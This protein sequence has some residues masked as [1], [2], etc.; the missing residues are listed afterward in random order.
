MTSV[1]VVD[2]VTLEFVNVFPVGANGA[3]VIGP[4]P[5]IVLETSEDPMVL[6]SVKDADGTITLVADPVKVQA[7]TAQAWTALRLE[8][9][10]LLQQSDWVALSDAHLSQDKKDAW[11]AYRQALR[12]LPDELA[13]TV[14]EGAGPPDLFEWPLDPTVVVQAPASGSRLSSLL[15]HADVEPVPPV[16][17]VTEV[18]EPVQ[19]VTEVQEVPE[20]PVAEEPVVEV[21]VVEPVVESPVVVEPVV[22]VPEVQEVVEVP[23]V[24]EVPEV[25][26]VVEVPEVQEVVEV[27]VV[28]EVPEVPE[29][30]EVVEV[31]EV[32]EVV[33]VPEPA[34]VELAASEPVV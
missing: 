7:K 23:V 17:E 8:R 11:F 32:Q 6:V 33:E 28:E 31:P 5:Q 27:P 14:P 22:E 2:S 21:P 19:E 3:V 30:Q 4:N 1:I 12:D 15:T 29:V 18:V 16:V 13:N 20:V 10:R 9:N 26:E 34:P 24:E 25:Q